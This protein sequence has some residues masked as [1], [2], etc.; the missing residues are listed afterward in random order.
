MRSAHTQVGNRKQY[1]ADAS[2]SVEHSPT[3]KQKKPKRQAAPSSLL[4]SARSIE[5]CRK[6]LT[7]ADVSYSLLVVSTAAAGTRS[8]VSVTSVGSALYTV[9]APPVVSGEHDTLT[10]WPWPAARWCLT[11]LSVQPSPSHWVLWTPVVD[12]IY[13]FWR[14]RIRGETHSA[15]GW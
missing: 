6:V 10:V 12:Q 3:K 8:S 7:N 5:R 1:G 11:P 2:S 13:S 15:I 14:I 4:M 9:L